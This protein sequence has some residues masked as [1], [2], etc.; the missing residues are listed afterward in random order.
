MSDARDQSMNHE[1][2]NPILNQSR[3]E[4]EM[5]ANAKDGLLAALEWQTAGD[6]FTRKLSSL[7]FAA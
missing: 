5:L 2:V 7:R 1:E 6:T 3:V 4:Q